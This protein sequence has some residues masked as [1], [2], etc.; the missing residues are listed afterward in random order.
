M[1]KIL[2]RNSIFSNGYQTIGHSYTKPKEKS[3]QLNI[4]LINK[5]NAKEITDLNKSKNYIF[6]RENT[7]KVFGS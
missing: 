7:V 3:L 1:Q 5:T 2:W 6:L 4:I